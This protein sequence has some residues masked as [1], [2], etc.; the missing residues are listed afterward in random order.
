MR[1]SVVIN[2]YNR[3]ASLAK[4]LDGLLHQTHTDFEVVVVNGPSDDGT[5]EL[6]EQRSGAVRAVDCAERNLAVSRNLGIDAASGD[7]VAFIDDDAVPEGRWLEDLAAAYENPRTGG[8]G[9]LT[10]DHTGT[11]VQY[12]YSI[13]DRI[14]HT[15]FDRTPP[16]DA[17]NRP[18]A[19][20]FLYLQGTNCSFRRDTLV[21]AEGF[22]EEIEYN[23]DES[24][25]CSRIIDSGLEL[26][27]LA[28]AVVHHRFLPSHMRRKEGFTDP[29]LPIKNRVYF[30]LR[31]GREHRSTLDTLNSLT[32]YVAEVKAWM[33][34]AVR[35]GHFTPEE[36]EHF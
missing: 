23:Y 19:D 11:R 34:D 5:A 24:E 36:H 15:D 18:G 30:A 13:C 7:V 16:F 33:L 1:F 26:R 14:G 3:A 6:L 21:A 27:A 2:T 35:L 32:E 20:P 9:G 8:A 22:D 25:I 4:T 29:F 10:L 17:L 12:R 31:V 28:D